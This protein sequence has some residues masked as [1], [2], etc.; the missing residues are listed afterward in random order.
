MHNSPV[1]WPPGGGQVA[2]PEG[3]NAVEFDW[4]ALQLL[5]YRSN[6]NFLTG[7]NFYYLISSEISDPAPSMNGFIDYAVEKYDV[8]GFIMLAGNSV[9]QG[10]FHIGKIAAKLRAGLGR[11]I[12][13]IRL[14]LEDIF[15][16][17][18]SMDSQSIT[19]NDLPG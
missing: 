19:L 11:K 1:S 10:G 8:G 16:V 15:N 3:M 9:E 6:V 4:L 14:S 18:S 17:V 13:H 12:E 7:E 5:R 2:A